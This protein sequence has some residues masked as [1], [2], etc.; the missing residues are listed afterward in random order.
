M[1][2][3]ALQS[4]SGHVT[5]SDLPPVFAKL[6]GING[7]Y[8]ESEVRAVLEDS[9][10]DMTHEIDFESFLRVSFVSNYVI[11]CNVENMYEAKPVQA[12]IALG[13]NILAF[14]VEPAGKVQVIN[15]LLQF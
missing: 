1:Q 5:V 4:R 3:S 13:R 14:K 8:P 11:N 6:K 10:P 12:L 7:I 2:Y 15:E 9:Y